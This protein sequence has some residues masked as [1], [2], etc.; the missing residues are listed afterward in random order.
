MYPTWNQNQPTNHLL[1]CHYRLV[2]SATALIPCSCLRTLALSIWVAVISINRVWLILSLFPVSILHL[3]LCPV[4]TL[5]SSVLSAEP[6]SGIGFS[7]FDPGNCRIRV[8]RTQKQ[9]EN[10]INIGW[11]RRGEKKSKWGSGE[12]L[13]VNIKMDVTWNKIW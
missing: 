3:Q 11:K 2:A 5:H 4:F 12:L 6:I 8:E 13:G 9:W 7:T 10:G 1:V